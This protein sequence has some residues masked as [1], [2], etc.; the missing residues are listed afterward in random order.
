MQKTF[1]KY[2]TG[3]LV[4]KEITHTIKRIVKNDL[5]TIQKLK[6]QV[7]ILKICKKIFP[8][9]NVEIE[10]CLLKFENIQEIIYQ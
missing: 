4:T 3:S 5:Q 6:K 7:I 8:N 1:S 9:C 2:W 10:E